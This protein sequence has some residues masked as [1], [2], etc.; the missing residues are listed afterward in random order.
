M[1]KL[2]E[3]RSLPLLLLPAAVANFEIFVF[4][5]HPRGDCS[6][7]KI[8]SSLGTSGMKLMCGIKPMYVM[9]FVW[10]VRRANGPSRIKVCSILRTH[11]HDPSR[12]RSQSIR[13]WY[14]VTGP[15]QRI[16]L[17]YK[18]V[19]ISAPFAC[20]INHDLLNSPKTLGLKPNR[21]PNVHPVLTSRKHTNPPHKN[22]RPG[23][24]SK[25]IIS[26]TYRSCNKG[27]RNLGEMVH[28]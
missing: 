27:R 5:S 9:F 20:F 8:R 24:A 4:S 17:Q 15:L 18:I 25:Q 26:I 16:H 13:C 1:W 7:T 28:G 14:P 23:K 19:Q 12:G 3:I 6:P 11:T 2:C 10:G 21:K 22:K